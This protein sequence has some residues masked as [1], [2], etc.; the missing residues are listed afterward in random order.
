MLKKLDKL[1]KW[2]DTFKAI[3]NPIR[4]AILFM[5]Y[6]SQV[7]Y[8]EHSLTL[9]QMLAV[10]GFPKTK[11]S[12]NTLTYHIGGLLEASLVERTPHQKEEGKSQVQTVYHLSKK[13]RD[14]L[15]DFNLTDKIK[16]YL[17]SQSVNEQ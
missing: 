5:L 16:E 13:G 12:M 4:L 11:R 15:K 3:G 2:A 7:M 6:G 9:S 17:E 8:G 1:E 14:F 10:L